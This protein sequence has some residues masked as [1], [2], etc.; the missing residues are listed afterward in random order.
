MKENGCV[1]NFGKFRRRVG[2]RERVTEIPVL[3]AAMG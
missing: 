2:L 1:L 3:R